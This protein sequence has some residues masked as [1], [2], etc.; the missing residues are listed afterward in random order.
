MQTKNQ[1]LQTLINQNGYHKLRKKD[2]SKLLDEYCRNTNA[3]RKYVIRKIRGGKYLPKPKRLT[4]I[5][6]KSVYD[7]EVVACLALIWQIFDYPCGQRLKTLL[8]TEVDRLKNLGELSCSDIVASKLKKISPRSIDNKLTRQKEALLLKSKY[9]KPASPLLYQK[10]PVKVYSEQDR[11]NTGHV[12]I[13]L[14]EH[15]GSSAAGE[16]GYT[17]SS[18]D[19][20]TNW[21]EG[22]AILT[23]AQ[24][25]IRR[26]T[27]QVRSRYPLKWKSLH[28]DNGREFIN[29]LIY[30][31]SQLSNLEFTRS[32]P[33]RKNDNF[34]VEQ[35]NSTHVRRTVGWLR[36]DTEEEIKLI[37]DLYRN[38]LRLYKN[39]FQP[40]IRLNSKTRVNGKI[41]RKYDKAK[42]PY[43]III[44]DENIKAE[45]KEQLTTIYLSL[46]PA[47][48]QRTIKA[49]LDILTKIYQQKQVSQTANK[50]KVLVP[51]TVTFLNCS[52][53][54]VSVT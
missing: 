21:W 47:E 36:Y 34:L 53:N 38:E 13:D 50:D 44:E 17:L 41:K 37:N 42:T 9:S 24:K 45:T 39:F 6:R 11:I 46:N 1:Y 2:K 22:E 35:K 52:T 19:L 49:K 5:R 40:V 54:T 3:N 8:E 18:T 10:I 26:A 29:A 14:V 25:V 31:Y 33:Y 23:K 15:C 27:E 48:L 12:Q 30:E 51:A 4:P 28:S 20:A 32:R 7:G 16:Y 43:Q